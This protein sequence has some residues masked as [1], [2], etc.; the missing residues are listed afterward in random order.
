MKLITAMIMRNEADRYLEEVLTRANEYSDK[1]VILDD[2]S[3]DHSVEKAEFH[4][5]K[6]YTHDDESLFWEQEHTL[7]EY[8]W[9]HIL[10]RE[11]HTNDWILALDCDEILSDYFLTVKDQLLSQDNIGTFTFRIYEAWGSRDKIRIDK[12]WN[13]MGKETPMLTRF[14]PSVNYMFP[15]IGLHSG[16]LPMNVIG[17]VIPSGINMLHLGWANPEEHAD[18][19]KRYVEMDKNPHPIMKA[20]YQSMTET[21]T[22]IDWFL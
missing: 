12:T 22:L 7:R 10:P 15:Q 13:P 19:I 21:P 3:T 17:P 6:V 18:K 2:N 8:L 20:H 16:R 1:I 4:G 5:A 11:A 14:T 9:K